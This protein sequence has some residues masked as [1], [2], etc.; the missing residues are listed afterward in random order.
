MLPNI[1]IPDKEWLEILK[2][3]MI[4]AGPET[5]HVITDFDRTLTKAFVGGKKIPSL[6]SVLRNGNYLT[7]GYAE[8][9][10]GLFNKY[11]P[12]EVNPD[13]PEGEKKKAMLSWWREHFDLLIKSG[14]NKKDIEDAVGSGDICIRSDLP[15][16]LEILNKYGIPVAIISSNGLGGDSISMYLKRKNL[17]YDNVHVISNSY[18]WDKNGNAV[19]VKEPI[20]H[21]ANKDETA[22]RDTPVFDLIKGRKNVILIGDSIEDIK[23]V[24][25]FDYDNIIKI[26]FLNENSEKSIDMF[27]RSFDVIILNDSGMGYVNSLLGEILGRD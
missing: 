24:S 25:G 19:G 21:S 17:A 12:I 2:K 14:L 16:F 4:Q 15:D 3:K 27:R 20:I 9:A 11:H 10:H 1:L 13:I 22:I 8:K 7:S 26:G 23:M 5:I 18:I 6:I